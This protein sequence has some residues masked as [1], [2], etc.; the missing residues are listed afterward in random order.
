MYACTMNVCYV[1]VII[2][3][4][5]TTRVC[6]CVERMHVYVYAI[7]DLDVAMRKCMYVYMYVRASVIISPNQML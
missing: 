5:V 6:M 3:P 1:Y 7:T 4:N 2:N